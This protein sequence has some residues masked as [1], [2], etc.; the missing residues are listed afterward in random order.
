MIGMTEAGDAGRDLSW[1]DKLMRFK[2]FEGA[3][4]ITKAADRPEFQEKALELIKHKPCIIHAGVTGWGHTKMETGNSRAQ[5]V[6]KS[7]R[8]FIDRGFPARNIVLRID[9]IFPNEMGLKVACLALECRDK[10]CPDIKRVRISI[11]DDYHCA[12]EEM[13]RRG[14]EPIDGNGGFKNEMDRRPTPE[15]V[16]LVAESL[17]KAAPEQEFELCAEPELAAAYPDHFKWFG[18][19]SQRDCDIMGVIVPEGTGINGQNRYGCRCLKLKRELLD[20]KV[21]CPNNCAYC[22]WGQK[23]KGKN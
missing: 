17:M 13:I 14:Y 10:Y 11:Y 18:C 22:Y 19:L 3:I 2:G 9:P 23:G 7:L 6:L 15:Q 20:N 16:K 12:R 1:Y 21:R 8:A 4:L 5:D